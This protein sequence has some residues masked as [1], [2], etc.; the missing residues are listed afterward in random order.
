MLFPKCEKMRRVS[1]PAHF[2]VELSEQLYID[3]AF[4]I[5]LDVD[6]QRVEA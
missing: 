6:E 2:Y 1:L 4:G 5:L 3:V